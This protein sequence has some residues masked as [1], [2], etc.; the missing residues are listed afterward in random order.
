MTNEMVSEEAW[1]SLS[2]EATLEALHAAANGLS[3]EESKRR[4]GIFGEN[5]L[6]AAVPT[7]KW[8]VF[9]LQFKSPLIA[10]LIV[11]G[12][13]TMALDHHVDAIAIF[14][15]L[16]LNAI[17][18][19]Y[20]EI[21]A[22]QA[23]RALASLS[24]PTS[25][26]VRDGRVTSLSTPSIVPGD[27]VLLESGDRVPADLRLIEANNLRIDESMLTGESEDASKNT[28]AS[29]RDAP[30][31]D[32]KSIAFS[33]TMVTGGRGRGV[34]VGTG[35]NTE[36]GEIN[37]LVIGTHASTPLEQIM[38]R[39]ERGIAIAVIIVALF[40][41]IGGTIINGN[42]TD[43]F[44]SSVALAVAAMP[45]ALP[46]VLTVAMSLAVSRMARRNAIVRTLPAVETLGSATV[47]GSDKTGTLTQNRMTVETCSIGGAQPHECRSQEDIESQPWKDGV[48]RLLRAGALTNEA[49]RHVEAS[50][51]V[52]YGGDAVDVAM[53]RAADDMGAVSQADRDLSIAFETPYEPEL[54]YSMTIRR[55]DDGSYTQYVKGAP[56]TVAAM[57]AAMAVEG[58]GTGEAGDGSTATEPIDLTRIDEV[59]EAMGG[60]GLRVIGVAM[61]ELG[62]DAR[63]QDYREPE[64]MIFLGL[65]GMLDPPR[66]GVREAIAQCAQA[67]IEVKMITG[68]H[69]LTAQAIGERLGLRH[70]DNAITGGEMLEMSDEVLKARLKETSIAA[71]VSP[72]DKLRIVEA[73]QDEGHT[74]AVTGDGVNDA[75]ALKAA[76]VGIAMGESGT[77]VA[78]EASDV[79]L[80]DDNFVTITQAVREGRVTF[81][82]IRGSA[83]FLLSTA[84]AAMIAVGINVIAEMPLLFTPLQMLWINFVTNGVQ[85]IALAFEPGQGDEL[86]RP[87]R[88]ASEGLLSMAMWAR[89]AV[90]G[91]WMAICILVMF[92]VMLDGGYEETT[93]RTMTLTLLVLFNFFMSMSARSENI[94]IFRLN[95]LRNPFLLVAAVL[96][97]VVHAT[98]MYIPAAAAVL[99]VG[100]LSAMEWLICWALA[101]SVLV[102]SE[103]DKLIRALMAKF[104]YTGARSGLRAAGHKARRGV[105]RLLNNS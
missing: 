54:R 24:T 64:S 77:D 1:H 41:F 15:V 72:Q 42:P 56:D 6:E 70:T 66:E 50:G 39:T 58:D 53:A 14:V 47:I 44:L 36:L 89:T 95:P 20:Q 75:P 3:N 73:L 31:G 45:E 13:V 74:V 97:L 23:V 5:A 35:S 62:P 59:Y 84:V 57:C 21:K 27:V 71:R 94:S 4:L 26:V 8:K 81:K 40:V 101:L 78:R 80:T 30:L 37:D 55:N 9:L 65:E 105:L 68:D 34:V 104:G 10:V 7:P 29:D 82:A 19:F 61:R 16:L 11:C 32:R 99:G 67:G 28:K 60:K 87:P 76:S 102:F 2:P 92:R 52:R 22:N 100:P 79:V 103:G 93:A 90:C 38:S 63:P 46:I 33:G 18:G 88:K 85:D 43:A 51:E 98:V 96:A 25:R 49:H 69:P 12:I 91:L 86:S 48:A 83:F 17:I